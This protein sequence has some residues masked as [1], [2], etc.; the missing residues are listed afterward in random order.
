MASLSGSQSKESASIS[1]FVSFGSM[2]VTCSAFGFRRD[3]LQFEFGARFNCVFDRRD[4]LVEV[5]PSVRIFCH[6][7]FQESHN[8]KFFILFWVAVL[9]NVSVVVIAGCFDQNGQPVDWWLILKLPALRDNPT[10]FIAQG[11]GYAY[12][13]ARNLLLKVAEGSIRDSRSL[14]GTL[15]QIYN[16][17]LIRCHPL[18]PW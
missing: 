7:S 14:I 6:C 18:R 15:N 2:L 13:D 9:F 8:M 12:L 5:R 17:T 10:P 3:E 4:E 16:R 11:Y 1:L